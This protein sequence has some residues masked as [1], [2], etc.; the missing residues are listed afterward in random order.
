MGISDG[1]SFGGADPVSSE[2]D[3]DAALAA[4]FEAA[5]GDPLATPPDDAA[6]EPATP[7]VRDP[8]SG[9]FAP[10]SD[11]PAP[12]TEADTSTGDPVVEAYLAKYGGDTAAALKAAANQTDVIG[13]QGQELGQT[14]QELAR[15][16]GQVE[17]LTATAAK[18]A[19]PALS[20]D[21]VEEYAVDVAV[22]D[23]Y[24]QGATALAN[25]GWTN[26]DERAYDT[27]IRNWA[28]EDPIAATR[29]DGGFQAWKRE[30]NAPA[31]T[32]PAT[33]PRLERVLDEQGVNDMVQTLDVVA[34]E[35]GDTW[36]GIAPFMDAAL[37]QVHPSVLALIASGSAE[38]KLAGTRMIADKAQLLAL[39]GVQ[40]PEQIAAAAAVERKRA[41]AAVATGSLRPAG[42]QQGA[43]TTKEEAIAALKADILASGGMSTESG[44]TVGGKPI[45][46]A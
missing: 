2:T 28:L 11:T 13:R 31:P 26:G 23:G 43:P 29:F 17:A 42:E 22:R 18:P 20:N 46:Q 30:Q 39:S 40:T 4:K 32:A 16:Q 24:F 38:D 44:L 45:G 25:E 34:K 41:G 35:R 14:R 33:D 21:Q 5:G 8:E 19:A 15:L 27:L 6:T 1:L 10:A 36:A 7:Q 12:G 3:F 9:Q 37:E